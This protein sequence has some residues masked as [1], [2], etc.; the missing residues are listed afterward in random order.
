MIVAALIVGSL[1]FWIAVLGYLYK[2][3]DLSRYDSP[4]PE[5]MITES[6]VSED[7]Q[8]VLEILRDY[9]SQ[10][11]TL[12][13]KVG[14]QRFEDV[15]AREVLIETREVNIEG[16][17]AEW[18]IAENS[19][20]DRRLLY[21]HGG[22]FTV[23]SP[24]THRHI[25]ASIAR[26]T[27]LSVLSIDYR[28]QPEHKITACH[29]DARKAYEWILNNGPDG[30]GPSSSLFV[31]G[32]SAGGN[33]TLAV[34]AWARKQGWQPANGAIAMAPLTDATLSG[35]TWQTNKD[36]DPFLGPSVGRV[37]VI[38]TFIRSISWPT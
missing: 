9:H 21:I 26:R 7:H 20:P 11:K 29:E 31:A 37:L 15:F 13:V 1:V 36:T 25:T 2:A 22:A 6:E 19:D 14:R 34:V 18:V 33:L 8:K 17:P 32:D 38:P 35:P 16:L 24:K 4:E 12:D 5:P 23:G 28:M 3:P 10:P 27:G 30:S